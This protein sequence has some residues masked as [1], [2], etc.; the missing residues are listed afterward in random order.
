MGI[1]SLVNVGQPL[2]FT[3][4]VFVAE[5]CR[6]VLYYYFQFFF[7]SVFSQFHSR[8]GKEV[9]SKRM[10]MGVGVGDTAGVVK[11]NFY[12]DPD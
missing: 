7:I 1:R 5:W 4:T 10:S 12:V 9:G 2:H 11:K 6:S 3:G 8:L